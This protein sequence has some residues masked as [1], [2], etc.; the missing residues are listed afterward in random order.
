MS[1]HPIID[2]LR[3]GAPSPCLFYP[4]AVR[5]GVPLKT[6]LTDAAAQAEVL[7]S[8]ERDTPCGAVIRMTELWCEAAAFGM[9][10]TLDE[11]E[12]PK[13]GEPVYCDAEELAGITIPEPVNAVT[14]PLIEAVRLAAPRL[15]RPLIVGV[16]APYTLGSVLCGSEDFMINCMM[17]P[18]LTHGFL[19]RLTQF[20][21]G[22]IE[23]YKNAGAAGVM[24][25]EPSV[26]MISPEMTEE[27]SNEYIKQILHEVSDDDFAVIYHNCGEVS[28][29]LPVIAKLDVDAFHFGSDVS[30]E[31]ALDAI[32]PDRPVMGNIDP[33]LFV[34][35]T[36][37]S[38][39]AAVRDL[40]R[41]CGNSDRWILSTGCDLAPGA[42]PENIAAFFSAK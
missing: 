32:D 30:P 2:R 5:R 38:V 37:A 18:E 7:C 31:A 25:A 9:D 27:F 1:H 11:G 22:Y 36:P 26:A 39:S 8:I 20:L 21:I 34:A 29:H 42:K 17:E 23:E 24:L 41:R 16:T 10:C 13:L 6:L 12:F 35:G 14:E 3:T 4:A 28:A 40:R 19:Q 33:R 15:S